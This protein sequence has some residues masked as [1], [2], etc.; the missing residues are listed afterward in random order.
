MTGADAVTL[1]ADLEPRV[2]VPAH[3]DGWSH[4]HDGENGIRTAVN[5]APASVKQAVWWLPDGI[6]TSV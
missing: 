5:T 4:F 6:P 3:Y 2:V 1:I